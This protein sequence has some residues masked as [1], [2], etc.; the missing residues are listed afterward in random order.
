MESDAARASRVCWVDLATTDPDASGEFYRGL[1]GWTA[2]ERQVSAGRFTVFSCV[3]GPVGSMYQLDASQVA[4]GVPAHWMAYVSVPDVDR[5]AELAAGLGGQVLVPP[6]TVA[7]V[8]RF[9]VIADPTGA[10]LG[11]WQGPGPPHD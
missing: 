9:A 11:L 7:G 4:G 5:A 2:E 8:A 10:V 3:D 1:F 6:Q